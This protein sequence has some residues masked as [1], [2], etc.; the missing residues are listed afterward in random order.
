M[1]KS[2][3]GKAVMC[4]EDQGQEWEVLSGLYSVPNRPESIG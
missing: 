4:L 3:T 1:K 2:S